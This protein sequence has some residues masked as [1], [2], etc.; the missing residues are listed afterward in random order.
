MVKLNIKN[1]NISSC[2]S[3]LQL[4]KNS[5]S[6]LLLDLGVG[7]Q[8]I[9]QYHFL[10]NNKVNIVSLDKTAGLI[11]TVLGT[12]LRVGC[13]IQVIEDNVGDNLN[14]DDYLTLTHNLFLDGK[15]KIVD[16]LNSDGHIITTSSLKN[17]DSKLKYSYNF[18]SNTVTF[19]FNYTNNFSLDKITNMIDDV[20]KPLISGTN[21]YGPTIVTE[22]LECKDQGTAESQLKCLTASKNM[23]NDFTNPGGWG[24]RCL[25]S[26]NNCLSEPSLIS[27]GGDGGRGDGTKDPDPTPGDNI[28]SI[29]TDKQFS[30]FNTTYNN[31]KPDIE[32]TWNKDPSNPVYEV[33]NLNSIYSYKY[34]KYIGICT[35]V[36][37]P[38]VNV[39]V[40][41]SK[42]PSWN[43]D[44]TNWSSFAD[45]SYKKPDL[46]GTVS[47]ES[48]IFFINNKSNVNYNTLAEQT[49]ASGKKTLGLTYFNGT[50]ALIEY[51]NDLYYF[52]GMIGVPEA[53][54]SNLCC[55]KLELSDNE[56]KATCTILQEDICPQPRIPESNKLMVGIIND[57]KIINGQW[58]I[59]L[60]SNYPLLWYSTPVDNNKPFGK[61]NT[62]KV[63]CSYVDRMITGGYVSTSDRLLGIMFGSPQPN[64]EGSLSN[65]GIYAKWLQPRFIFFGQDKN[66]TNHV[67]G[68]TPGSQLA[69]G[70]NIAHILLPPNPNFP[71]TGTLKIYAPDAEKA[72]EGTLLKTISNYI[73]KSKQQID[74]IDN[75]TDSIVNDDSDTKLEN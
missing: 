45:L 32:S 52:F 48:K 53:S 30:Y 4:T 34:N 16:L 31:I 26:C 1:K 12:A 43:L 54:N 63:L 29:Y 42:Y 51:K 56:E 49:D 57:V 38:S 6:T 47:R 33:N 20:R 3:L 25:K 24:F 55:G 68:I 59:L 64:Y 22:T 27:Y 74:N 66:G 67:L 7:D 39:P 10:D 61:W 71:Y 35:V 62:P 21:L 65:S 46:K 23:C 41:V 70:S 60:H 15:D 19:L 17:T 5:L 73:I 44:G 18:P 37:T 36:F 40:L 69:N 11:G 50:N 75:I 8:L 13:T 72:D 9:I 14:T 2:Q 28:Y 58:I